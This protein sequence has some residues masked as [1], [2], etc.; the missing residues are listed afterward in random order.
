MLISPSSPSANLDVPTVERWP[1]P[2]ADE[3]LYSYVA[4]LA[5]VN[6]ISDRM[7]LRRVLR[8]PDG[9]S[10]V[11]ARFHFN[12]FCRNSNGGLGIPRDAL[13]QLTIVPLA[14]R[15]GD[16]D[17]EVVNSIAEGRLRLNLGMDEFGGAC[18]WRHCEDC[19]ARDLVEYGVGYW[20]RVH[21]LPTSMFCGRHG[22]PLRQVEMRAAETH[23]HAYLPHH[24]R[25]R[26]PTALPEWNAKEECIWLALS[27]IGLD[28]LQDSEHFVPRR[29][30]VQALAAGLEQAGFITRAGELRKREFA[31][32]FQDRF[33]D[34]NAPG[35]LPR[36]DAVLR[37]RDLWPRK[38]D[39]GQR[40]LLLALLLVH[41]LFGSWRLFREQCR[42]EDVLSEP[43]QRADSVAEGS[44]EEGA[45]RARMRHRGTCLAYM[46]R[47]PAP[48]SQGLAAESPKT[49]RWL[50]TYDRDWLT[51]TLTVNRTGRFQLTLFG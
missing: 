39:S 48:T 16:V 44:A 35:L 40:R 28:A 24:L 2:L 3:S 19:Y 37:P 32:A 47:N 8:V 7:L 43:D 26:P 20:R 12:E 41:W 51:K 18:R 42:W 17:P 5:L 46:S 4:R 34:I 23:Y 49:H 30:A 27:S 14:A 21:Q 6:S 13:Q 1:A 29:A 22:K 50:R 33:G 10:I 31:R 11:L 45:E 15:L 25:T 38:K 36:A 9:L